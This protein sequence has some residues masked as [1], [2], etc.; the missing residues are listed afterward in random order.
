VNNDVARAAS[1]F[2]VA[3]LPAAA[4]ITGNAYLH[5]D[6]FAAGFHTAAFIA[7]ALCGAGGLLAAVG[8]R[9]P[10]R[11][12]RARQAAKRPLLSCAL[13]APPHAARDGRR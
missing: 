8:L 5:P 1:L 6:R 13:D 9:N 2:A 12:V 4:G 10:A 7:A 11:A 3:L